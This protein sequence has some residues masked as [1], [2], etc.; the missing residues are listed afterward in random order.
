VHSRGLLERCGGDETVRRERCFGDAE[1][2]WRAVGGLAAAVHH[3]VVLFHEAEAI[4][5]LPYYLIA[6]EVRIAKLSSPNNGPL[7]P[8]KEGSLDLPLNLAS[9]EPQAMRNSA[10][11]NSSQNPSGLSIAFAPRALATIMLA[12]VASAGSRPAY[13]LRRCLY[14][15]ACVR[16]KT[17]RTM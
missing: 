9:A 14:F 7:A 3:F 12:V 17:D 1:E 5:L 16:L 4:D 15:G 8:G 2:E 11:R 10:A 6:E 13:F